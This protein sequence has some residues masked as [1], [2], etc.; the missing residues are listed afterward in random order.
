[1][2]DASRRLH[3]GLFL[4]GVGHHVAA[5]RHP[6]VWPRHL[7]AF[8]HYRDIALRAEAAKFDMVFLADSLVARNW[9]AMPEVARREG[10][11]VHFEPLTLL[12]ALSSVTRHIGLAATASTTYNDPPS[13]SREI[14]LARPFELRPRRL[15][16]VTS[17]D[18][19]EAANFGS[20]PHTDHAAR[21]AR[22]HEF[23]DVVTS[24]WDSW[25]KD[26]IVADQ[27]SGIFYDRSRVH[28]TRA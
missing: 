27:A 10:H 19:S 1:M 15:N 11:I 5:W 20:A 25:E 14:C 3:L 17:A 8:S 4:R 12:S 23:L 18:S 24:L 7:L 28:E 2:A 16:V 6:Q 13:R 9:G 22:A 21:Y 26:A